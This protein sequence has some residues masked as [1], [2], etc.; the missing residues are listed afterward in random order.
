MEF[1]ITASFRQTMNFFE[2]LAVAYTEQ[3]RWGDSPHCPHCGTLSVYMMTGRD[4]QRE[5]HYR[6][7]CRECNQQFTVKTGTLFEDSRV[8]ML[9]WLMAIRF[10]ASPEGLT[11]RELSGE[12]GMTY[13]TAL[14]VLR[15][16]RYGFTN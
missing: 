12:T 10:A 7:R 9:W 11:A 1:L 14:F 15:R 8:P 6:W 5:K 4:G 2:D 13:K 16:L 3:Q